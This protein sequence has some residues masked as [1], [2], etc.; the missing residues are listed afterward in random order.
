MQQRISSLNRGLHEMNQ[1]VAGA[2]GMTP[3]GSIFD[4][5]TPKNVS[6]QQP[7][8]HS[9]QNPDSS[10]SSFY[11]IL[12]KSGRDAPRSHPNH[13]SIVTAQRDRASEDDRVGRAIKSANSIELQMALEVQQRLDSD[14]ALSTLLDHRVKEL[15]STAEK[16]CNERVIQLHVAVDQMTKR[17]ESLSLELSVE[18]EKNVRLAKEL[19]RHS[20][21]GF[22]ELKSSIERDKAMREDRESQLNSKLNEA[23]FKLKERL[24]VE[25]HAREQLLQHVHEE[26]RKIAK[27]RE[28]DDGRIL[29]QLKSDL[30]QLQGQLKRET[31]VRE[32][33]EEQLAIAMEDVVSRVKLGLKALS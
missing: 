13:V 20:Q 32:V 5:T 14:T 12:T 18:R 21:Q 23:T 15:S 26:I 7:H 25:R 4:S 6:N 17:V 10:P 8:P 2:T 33:G 24:D 1:F 19:Q 3:R 31:E 30:I 9:P 22:D 16:F 29:N 27:R 28:K 11:S